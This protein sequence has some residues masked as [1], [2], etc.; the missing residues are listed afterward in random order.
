MPGVSA[1][2]SVLQQFID[3]SMTIVRKSRGGRTHDIGGKAGVNNTLS[4]FVMTYDD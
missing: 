1:G 3:D 4:H 2:S